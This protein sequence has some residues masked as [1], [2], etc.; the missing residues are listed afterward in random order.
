MCL[1]SLAQNQLRQ[2]PRRLRFPDRRQQSSIF[3]APSAGGA[4]KL[5]DVAAALAV[6][7]GSR[8]ADTQATRISII[9]GLRA[10]RLAKV[11]CRQY[12]F[13]GVC[14]RGYDVTRPSILRCERWHSARVSTA[15]DGSPGIVTTSSPSARTIAAMSVSHAAPT[16]SVNTGA[17]AWSFDYGTK[18]SP[19]C[20]AMGI[21]S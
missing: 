20:D 1:F 2:T 8:T 5:E 17:L 11:G 18:Y 13:C 7:L 9:H 21:S 3:Y 4:R 16:P 6:V 10:S 19:S 12:E 15:R 14:Y